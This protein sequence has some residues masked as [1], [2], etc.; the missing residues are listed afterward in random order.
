[1]PK[2]PQKE[3]TNPEVLWRALS[4]QLR[5]E[6][7]VRRLAKCLREDIFVARC[8]DLEP[9]PSVLLLAPLPKEPLVALLSLL[10]FNGSASRLLI[11]WTC[12]CIECL[13]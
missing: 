13:L 9:V 6:E 10:T 4:A 2:A 1:M 11:F 7:T 8:T 12:L 5:A 3:N